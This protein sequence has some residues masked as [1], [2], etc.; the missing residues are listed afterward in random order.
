MESLGLMK[1]HVM[2]RYDPNRV[3]KN[4]TVV[5][6]EGVGGDALK[7]TRIDTDDPYFTLLGELIKATGGK[8]IGTTRGAD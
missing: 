5:I 2:V 1:K 8:K 6:D 7:T 4:F 3:E